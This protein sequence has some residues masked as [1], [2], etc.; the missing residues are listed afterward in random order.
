MQKKKVFQQI[1]HLSVRVDG[2]T[3]FE[4][5]SEKLLGI[6]ISDN[7][8]WK[9]HLHGETWREQNHKT[10]GLISQLSRRV[11][12]VKRLS[13]YMSRQR[14]KIF[15][16]GLFYSKLDYCLPVFGHVFGLD[17]YNVESQ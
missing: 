5:K 10:S 2:Q 14:L 6:V 8:T 13:K 12:M 16:D 15:A 1:G 7:L 17:R 9:E 11:G 4:S 3:I